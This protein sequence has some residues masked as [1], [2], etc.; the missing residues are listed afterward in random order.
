[1]VALAL[2]Y[3]EAA[4]ANQNINKSYYLHDVICLAETETRIEPNVP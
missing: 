3:Q 4:Q 1:M 2:C